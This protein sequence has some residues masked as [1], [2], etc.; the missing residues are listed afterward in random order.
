MR[1]KEPRDDLPVL[2]AWEAGQAGGGCQIPEKRPDNLKIRRK[3]DLCTDR[4]KSCISK[5]NTIT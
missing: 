1:G 3:T 4:K 5:I 2:S